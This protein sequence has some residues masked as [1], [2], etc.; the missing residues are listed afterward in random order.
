[1]KTLY[2][3]YYIFLI[4]TVYSDTFLISH[5]SNSDSCF[6][7]PTSIFKFNVSDTTLHSPPNGEVWPICLESFL[8]SQDLGVCGEFF[9]ST[10][11]QCCVTSL[12]LTLT[13]NYKSYSHVQLGDIGSDY[14]S[15]ITKTAN[16]G[17]YCHI[18]PTTTNLT[19]V[20]FNDMLF[21]ADDT[22]RDGT[23]KCTSDGSFLIYKNQDCSGP[24]ESYKLDSSKTVYQSET[25]GEF[26]GQILSITNA[27]NTFI[28]RTYDPLAL[29]L[30]NTTQVA[31]ILTHLCQLV[32]FG[33]IIGILI[34]PIQKIRAS[35]NPVILYTVLL[36]LFR[37]ILLGI[38]IV[39]WY[40]PLP[41]WEQVVYLGEVYYILSGLESLA[42][43]TFTFYLLIQLKL[44]DVKV[45]VRSIL[46]FIVFAVHIG[47]FGGNYFFIC[48]LPSIEPCIPI[49]MVY[50]WI[51]LDGYWTL[52]VFTWNI[53]PVALI[54]IQFR[55]RANQKE[56]L[57]K[58]IQY[59][60][61]LDKTYTTLLCLQIV[62]V[63]T[64]FG[65]GLLQVSTLLGDDK[66][67]YL[68]IHTLRTISGISEVF[69]S[70][71][72]EKIREMISKKFVT[73]N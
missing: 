66:S 71:M 41:S 65:V 55:R 19:P 45:R 50:K 18:E 51:A 57:F 23:Y 48:R 44:I 61:Q 31:D 27:Q 24:S 37:L 16:G 43:I 12:D 56:S 3:I 73:K 25:I 47:L 38:H 11:T 14:K 13:A 53:L 58:A 6:G 32:F 22:C 7:P 46:A 72:I 8:V 42:T 2:H 52:F 20:L 4:K 28:W 30:P 15:S 69:I 17:K 64:Y 26:F 54:P 67:F 36:N 70:V 5:W 39:Y 40:C 9:N 29:V 1:M 34:K 49:T 62:L 60:L 35:S 10:Y 33:S 68:S 59:V 63:I 21:L